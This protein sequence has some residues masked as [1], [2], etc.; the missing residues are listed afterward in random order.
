METGG[1]LVETSSSAEAQL[2]RLI[3]STSYGVEGRTQR[4]RSVKNDSNKL[5]FKAVDEGLTEAARLLVDAR[6][7]DVNARSWNFWTP[8]H[9]AA[10]SGQCLAA[11]LL[12]DRGADVNAR[13]DEGISPLHQA[14]Y[15]GHVETCRLL[16]ERGAEPDVRDKDGWAPIHYSAM[17]GNVLAT[18]LLLERGADPNAKTKRGAMPLLLAVS[19]KHRDV[20]GLLVKQKNIKLHV[21]DKN[22]ETVI[23]RCRDR[24]R[25]TEEI[26]ALIIHCLHEQLVD[27]ANS[28][29]TIV[30]RRT[31]SVLRPSKRQR[32][33]S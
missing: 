29:I 5:L 2:N 23:D 30:G 16:L 28:Y 21:V 3:S 11:E 6:G 33:D 14:V 8:L 9:C 4:R 17:N 31:S 18:A 7:A 25:G 19:H 12:V 1:L 15:E 20:V 10:T 24:S 27:L 22:D 32:D 26:R 13:A